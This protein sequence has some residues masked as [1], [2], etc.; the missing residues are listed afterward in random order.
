[1]IV[2]VLVGGLLDVLAAVLGA[3]PDASLPAIASTSLE[4]FAEEIGGALGGLDSLLPITEAAVFVGWVLGTYVPIAVAY[5][6]A[7][8]V[9][10]HLPV[11]GNGG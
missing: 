8:W 6:V 3:I 10:T 2:L 9:W 7:H 11:I 5:Y 4:D 1:M